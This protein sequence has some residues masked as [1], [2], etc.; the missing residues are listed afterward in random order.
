MAGIRRCRPQ[1]LEA[2][3]HGV[4]PGTD[5]ARAVPGPT[6]MT[7][8]PKPTVTIATFR[9]DPL[10][11]RIER[12]VT[13]LLKTS[14]VVTPIDVLIGMQLLTCKDVEDWRHGRIAYLERVINCNLTRL[15]RLLRILR[16]HAHDVNLV[17]STT[18]YRRH[19]KAKKHRLRFTKSGDIKLELAY[20]THY[21]WPGKSP[22]HPPASLDTQV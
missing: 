17:P 9:S 4:R 13:T 14:K 5:E 12:A 2:Y 20:A 16:F 21:V 3:S 7:R 18:D 19:G 1:W 6:G 15:S 10:F 11:P 22:F 8:H